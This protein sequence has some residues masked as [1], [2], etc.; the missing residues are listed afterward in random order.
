V[1]EIERLHR[2][3]GDAENVIR[4]ARQTGIE[5][6]PFREFNLNAVRLELSL[7]AKT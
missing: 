3:H 6:L 1:V 5:N 2:G 7:I 4:G